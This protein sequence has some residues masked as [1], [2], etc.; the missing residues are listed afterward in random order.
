MRGGKDKSASFAH[1]GANEGFRCQLIAYRTTGQGAVVM[2]NSDTGGEA[3]AEV[4]KAIGEHY[5]WPK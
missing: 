3:A 1:G 2:T 4:I 5:N